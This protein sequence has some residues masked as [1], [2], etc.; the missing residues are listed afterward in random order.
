MKRLLPLFAFFF[1][2]SFESNSQQLPLYTQY[3]FNPYMIN[4]SMVAY[5]NRP[6]LNL[7]Y[8]QQWA[9]VQ[10]G[11]KTLQ[12][13]FQLPLNSKMAI[14]VNV[15]ND[16]SVLLSSTS[17]L[18]TYGY[19][20]QLAPNHQL[21][22]GL[23]AG[24]YSNKLNLDEVA[25]ADLTDP[26]L[27]TSQNNSMVLD[28][29]FGAHYKFKNFVVGY[30]LVNLLNRSNYST[31]T[32]GDLKTVQLRNQIL[33]AS[34]R[35]SLVPDALYLQPNVAYRLSQNN[36]N[37]YE[38]SLVTS[39]RNIIDVG[40]GYRQNFGPTV[41]LRVHFKRLQVGASYDFPSNTAQV[42]GGGTREI[43]LKWSFGKLDEPIKAAKKNSTPPKNQEDIQPIIDEKPKDEAKVIKEESKAK[44]EVP[45]IITPPPVE[46]KP[47]TDED[48][49]YIIGAFESKANAQHFL[50]TVKKNGMKAEMKESKPGKVP[51][52]YYIHLPKYRSKE[53]S[54]DRVMELRK[55][56]KIDKAWFSKLN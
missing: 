48:Y 9:N 33:F 24:I 36:L 17:I 39:Y 47:A 37:Y 15:N 34:Y 10:D 19:K 20:I 56:T 18:A 4:P 16:K 8:R 3:A 51:Y 49:Y 32:T 26:V 5:S 40:G 52:Y 2:L 27:L 14:G 30:S 31:T 29:Q 55:I 53:V 1:L 54:L 41:M 45:L 13:D 42:S 43:Q 35:F 7:L 50:E 46:Q 38:A 21:G 23:S 25:P 11:P 28:G 12:F 6:E 44:V 22:F